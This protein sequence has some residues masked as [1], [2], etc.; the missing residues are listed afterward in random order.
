MNRRELLAG[1]GLLAGASQAKAF[2]LLG[3]EMGRLGAAGGPSAIPRNALFGVNMSGAEFAPNAGQRFPSAADWT[4]LASKGVGFVR[5]PIAWESLQPTLG[6]ALNSTYLANLKASIAAAHAVGIG[7]IVD[8]HNFGAYATSGFGSTVTYAGNSGAP[9]TGVH[10]L[11]DGTLTS[12]N[13]TDV[14]TKLATALVGTPGVIGYGLMNEP[15]AN[16]VGINLLQAPNYFDG[17]TGLTTWGHGATETVTRLALGTNPLGSNFGPAWNFSTTNFGNA[18]QSVNVPTTGTYTISGW[19]SSTA[20]QAAYFVLGGNQPGFTT[21]ATPT[22]FT[23]T[24]TLT[25]GANSIGIGTNGPGFSGTGTITIANLQLELASSATTYQPSP[26]APFAQAGVNAIRAVDA[27]TPIFLCGL[28]ALA[29]FW[30][31]YNFEMVTLTGSNLVFE[32][33]QYWDGADGIGGGGTYANTYTGFGVNPNSGVNDM[34]PYLSWLTTT[35][36]AGYLGEFG[37]PNSTADN[38]PLWLPL[39]VN[40]LNALKGANIKATQWFYGNNGIQSGN[41]LNIAPVGGVDDPRL[42]QMLAVH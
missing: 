19:A 37:T 34:T 28:R 35:G 39:Q 12:A 33:H 22:R 31:A 41:I 26:Y 25:A 10:F 20:P 29:S 11:G 40:A 15:S 18:T 6:G 2:G 14:W 9:A 1:A 36:V 7:V 3:A 13:L 16:I 21:S 38:N 5:H 32:G 30:Q 27:S 42:T 17:S 4:Y 24:G 8:L 23:A